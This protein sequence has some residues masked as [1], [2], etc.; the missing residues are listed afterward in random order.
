MKSRVLFCLII[1]LFFS[2]KN[3]KKVLPVLAPSNIASTNIFLNTD[4]SYTLKTPKGATIK[5]ANNSFDVPKNT[6]VKIELKEAYTA[7]DILLGGLTTTSNGRLLQSGGIVYFNASVKG[8]DVKIIK[9]INISVP[10]KSYNDSMQLFKGEI[11]EDSIINWVNPVL[12]DSTAKINE[13]YA[14]KSLFKANCA[15]CKKT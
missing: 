12:L 11:K 3:N 9:P 8:S 13:L 5:I 1:I 15:N 14:G 6:I 10:T 7:E 2:C 4:S